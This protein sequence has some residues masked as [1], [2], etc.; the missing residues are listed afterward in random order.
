MFCLAFW[1]VGQC[2]L[3]YFLAFGRLQTIFIVK[4]LKMSDSGYSSTEEDYEQIYLMFSKLKKT[5]EQLAD[6][7]ED[8]GDDSDRN[9]D[10]LSLAIFEAR[11]TEEVSMNNCQVFLRTSSF[12]IVFL[13]LAPAG[14]KAKLGLR[15]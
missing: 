5:D 4:K 2:L 1:L 12:S 13:A 10:D 6:Q 7:G 3:V 15:H 9:E 11:C 14:Y 8:S